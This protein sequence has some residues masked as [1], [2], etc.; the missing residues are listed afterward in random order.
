MK[1]NLFFASFN[2]N[3]F[4]LLGISVSGI[5]NGQQT[6]KKITQESNQMIV[7][8]YQIR[9]G[10]YITN[11]LGSGWYYQGGSQ[12]SGVIIPYLESTG[13]T[14]TENS[15]ISATPPTYVTEN[16]GNATFEQ[17]SPQPY[18]TSRGTNR[19]NWK[20]DNDNIPLPKQLTLTQY[21][22]DL[23]AQQDSDTD[24]DVL[25]SKFILPH[26]Y[27][28]GTV[29]P[30]GL[31]IILVS[32]NGY[33]SP[34]GGTHGGVAICLRFNGT[35]WIPQSHDPEGTPMPNIS[36]STLGISEVLSEKAIF[37]PNP[38]KDYFIIQ[39]SQKKNVGIEYQIL[40]LSGKLILTGKT[41]YNEK[42]NVQ[43]LEKGNYI[44]QIQS[45]TGEKQTLKL[46]KN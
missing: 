3:I 44:L 41:K 22:Y 32:R 13:Q 42:I 20:G 36:D 12:Q 40:D 25:K 38:A 18:T 10:T 46:L 4:L 27:N 11:V 16:I 45:E 35:Q 5:L 6:A 26:T 8:L 39:N 2:K 31:W 23:D 34:G 1:K 15:S 14:Y 21:D 17:A 9:N 29:L 28:D 7:E 19:L 33:I 37:Y 24:I 43:N 30:A